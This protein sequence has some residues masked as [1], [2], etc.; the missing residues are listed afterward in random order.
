MYCLLQYNLLSLD[1]PRTLLVNSTCIMTDKS[2]GIPLHEQI[3]GW[4]KDQIEKGVFGADAKLP[5]ENELTDRFDVSRVTV[6]RALKTLEEEHFIYRCQG[7]GSFV[8]DNRTRQNF[9]D[10]TD[11]S[12]DM[13]KAG[14]SGSSK[15]INQEIID[16]PAYIASI[17]NISEGQ[18]VMKLDRLRLGNDEPISFDITWIPIFYAQL[19]QSHNLTQ[20][21]IYDILENE[22]QIPI[23]RG[24]YRIEAEK[25][26]EYLSTHLQVDEGD[27]LLLIDRL[28]FT[29]GSKQV[30]YQKRYNRT[31]KMVYEMMV[32]RHN[33]LLTSN[34]NI[35]ANEV[36]NLRQKN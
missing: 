36:F 9:M 30:Y 3:S 12:E 26:D 4:I 7:L 20:R 10:L 28:T 19:I 2:N 35:P 25:A 29:L 27:A 34:G 15:V 14:L 8:K 16:C 11:F 33:G 23:E 32:E 17:L 13:R 31:D 6:R 5:S 22:Y 18:K 24:C 1:I 21:T